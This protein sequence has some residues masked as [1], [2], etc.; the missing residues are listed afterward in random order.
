MT[1]L[2]RKKA[3]EGKQKNRV[4]QTMKREQSTETMAPK[5]ES[6]RERHERDDA[7]KRKAKEMREK[8]THRQR[9]AWLQR[10]AKKVWTKQAPHQHQQNKNDDTLVEFYFKLK[11]RGEPHRFTTKEYQEVL[12]TYSKKMS[13]AK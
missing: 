3:R 13:T 7:I 6:N 9:V 5:P 1:I 10:I 2:N 4:R 11:K 8:R 12:S